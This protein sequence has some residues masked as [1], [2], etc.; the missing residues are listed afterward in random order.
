MNIDE[1]AEDI[2]NEFSEERNFI[3]V[4]LKSVKVL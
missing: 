1:I 3:A 4:H 2:V